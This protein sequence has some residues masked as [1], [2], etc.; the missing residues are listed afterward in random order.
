MTSAALR[1][2]THRLA[3]NRVTAETVSAL[4]AAGIEAIL[5]KG[6]SIA[7]WL[8]EDDGRRTYGD[9]DLLVDPVRFAEAEA[10]LAELGFDRIVSGEQLREAIPAHTWIR[11]NDRRIVDLHHRLPGAEVDPAAA[12]RLLSARTAELVIGPAR[13]RVFDTGARAM[14]VA[15][16]AAFHGVEE[17]HPLEDLRRALARLDDAIWRDAAEL[18]AR[19]SATPAFALG[20]RLEPRGESVANRLALP[21]A[22]SVE[23]RLRASTAPPLALGLERLASA[24]GWATKLA[25]VAREV[26]PSPVVLRSWSPLAHR[27]PLGMAGAYVLRPFW[28]LGHAPTAVSAW[29]RARRA[30]E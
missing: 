11:R 6:P 28:L 14:H 27:G 21:T 3:V 9:T 23:L 20:L 18:A 2:A 8:Y 5:L 17:A 1:A 12:W 29:R 24:P 30:G 10:V 25:I 26:V 15:I 7:R 16:H 22:S 13:C 19:L 4:E